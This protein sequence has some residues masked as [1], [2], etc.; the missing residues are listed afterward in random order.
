MLEDAG[1]WR[2]SGWIDPNKWPADCDD[3]KYEKNNDRAM[4]NSWA[5]PGWLISILEDLLG[6]PFDTDPFF[7]PYGVIGKRL[8][9]L[10]SG[11]HIATGRNLDDQGD[12]GLKCNVGDRILVNGPFSSPYAW[13]KAFSEVAYNEGSQVA[14]VCPNSPGVKWF[15]EFLWGADALLILKRTR[16]SPPPGIEETSP[17]GSTVVGLWGLPY[18]EGETTHE[19]RWVETPSGRV[20]L[21]IPPR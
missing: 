7:N 14:L 9:D 19:P 3:G 13:V 16:F 2:P 21:I 8:R 17:S 20:P 5:T 10:G 4:R 6:G 11:I 18:P 12:D 1:H 15:D